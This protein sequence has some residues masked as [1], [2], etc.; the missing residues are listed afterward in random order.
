MDHKR[1]KKKVKIS[2]IIKTVVSL[3]LAGSILAAVTIYLKNRVEDTFADETDNGIKSA[4]VESG[5]ISTT[6]YGTGRLSDDD[7]NTQ[8]IP[9][10]VEISE[11][12]IKVGDSV[13]EGD[14]IAVVD[15]SSVKTAM[16]ETQADIDELDGSLEE[17]AEEQ[18]EDTITT[19]VPG[20]V[21]KIYAAE[22]DDVSSVMIANDA[23][24]LLSLDG[25][26]AL[27]MSGTHLEVGDVVKILTS[28][29]KSFDGQVDSKSGDTV[30][31]L[32]SD[33]GPAFED[34][35]TV[36]KTT[37]NEDGTENETSIGCGKLYIHDPLSIVGYAGTVKSVSVSENDKVKA[38]KQLFELENTSYTANYESLLSS[39]KALEDKLLALVELYRSGAIVS[40]YEGV[41]QSIP[42]VE[43]DTSETSSADFVF[44]QDKTMSVSVSIDETDILSLSVGQKVD[45]SVTSFSEESFTG[46]ITEI[47]KKGESSD[48]GTTYTAKV[49]IGKAEG[50]LSGMSASAGIT[51]ESVDNALIIPVEALKQTSSTAYVYTSY[52]EETKTLGGMTE[53]ETGLSNSSY[54]EIKSGLS[55]GDLVYYREKTANNERTAP[56]GGH[57]GGSDQGNEWSFSGSSGSGS[58]KSRSSGSSSRNRGQ[59]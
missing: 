45:V 43:D 9:E 23:L 51:I 46:I 22:G 21:K 32:L 5:S 33:D 44:R 57:G 15:I 27:D 37:E 13:K 29:E 34:E 48:G 7:T 55:A 31:I 59:S 52:D 36:I 20:R 35:V 40:S 49:Q 10:G 2:K 39:R 12:T 56:G 53:V 4:T 8:S 11:V 19:S 50:M 17:A 54:V 30:T 1:R 14:K 18:I 42:T 28:D 25:Y 6:V 41:V 58:S 26:M 3:L 24:M 47:D 16:S 38:E